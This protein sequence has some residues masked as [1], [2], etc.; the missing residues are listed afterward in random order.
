MP[1]HRLEKINELIRQELGEILLKEG[2]IEPGVLVTILKVTA[3][4]DL[5]NADI[6]FSVWPNDKAEKIRARL[7]AQAG[8]LQSLLNKRV[9]FHPV[10]RIKFVLN[11]E[12]VE[13]QKIDALIKELNQE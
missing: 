3:T 11:T 4:D 10:P 13:G 7:E 8:W 12:E 9:T 6:I 2:D 5:K 1:T